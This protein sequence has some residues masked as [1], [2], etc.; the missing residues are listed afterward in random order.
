MKCCK[1][2]K[3]VD[4]KVSEIP[5]RWFGVYNAGKLVRIICDECLRKLGNKDY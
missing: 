3:E 5:P 1:C 2:D 4:E